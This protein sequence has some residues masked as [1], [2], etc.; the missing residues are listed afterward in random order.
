MTRGE[1]QMFSD[2]EGER[3]GA[4]LG[5]RRSSGPFTAFTAPQQPAGD[6]L[7]E[8]ARRGGLTAG[9]YAARSRDITP[10]DRRILI[11][12]Y[13]DP[14]QGVECDRWSADEQLDL[15]SLAAVFV[16]RVGVPAMDTL[17]A[18]PRALPDEV[19]HGALEGG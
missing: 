18:E 16:V 14:A 8:A 3:R 13:V 5:T 1:L 6:Q 7:P 4:A 19:V 15:R 9:C 11:P 2:P 10:R 12:G 17:L